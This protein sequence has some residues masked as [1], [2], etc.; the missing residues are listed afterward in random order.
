MH[1][2]FVGLM[3][4]ISNLAIHC[5]QQMHAYFVGLVLPMSNPANHVA[6]C[7][8]ADLVA[9]ETLLTDLVGAEQLHCRPPG[10]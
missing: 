10:C 1:A 7:L 8:P 2:Y 5:A 3:L 6:G 4:P 9:P